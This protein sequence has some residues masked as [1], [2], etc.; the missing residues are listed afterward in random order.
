MSIFSKIKARVTSA[1]TKTTVIAAGFTIALAS[2]AAL[3]TISGAAAA[4]SSTPN[5]T[6]DAAIWCGVSQSGS[7][8]NEIAQVKK[9]YANGDGHNKYYAIQDMYNYFGMS[10]SVIN[11]LSTSNVQS[12]YVTSTGDVYAGSTLVATGAIT[13]GRDNMTGSTT[14]KYGATTFYTRPTHIS[15]ENGELSALVIMKNGTF[16]NAILTSCGNP[17]KATSKKPAVSILK[18]VRAGTSGNYASSVTV[19]S[20]STVSYQI[21]ASS[22]GAISADNVTVK[23]AL[24]TGIAYTSGTLD[25]NGKAMTSTDASKFFGTGLNVGTVKNGSKDV[26]TFTAKAGTVV[27]T[28]AS[29][30]AAIMNN[31][32]TITATGL[33]AQTSGAKVTTTCTPPAPKA[34]LVCNLLT[35]APGAI[36]STTGNQTYSFTAKGTASNTAITGYAFDFGDT[37]TATTTTPTTTHTY[38]PGS[39]TATVTI[40]A[41]SLSATATTCKVTITVK[42]P[43][44]PAKPNYTIQKEVSTTQNG[45]YSSNVSVKSGATVYYKI[46]VSSTGNTPVTNVNVHDVMPTYLTYTN[47]TLQ[48]NGTAVT[49]T[50]TS[51]LFGKGLTVASIKNGSNVVFTYSAVAGNTA[52]DTDASCVAE[53]LTNTGTI[54]TT[55]LPSESG[56]ATT[57]TTCTEVKG[58]L[59]CVAIQPIAGTIDSTTGAQSYTFTGTATAANATIKT[60]TFTVTNTDTNKVV[61]TIPVT[62][63]VPTSPATSAVSLTPGNYSAT[64]TVSGTDLYGNAVSGSTNNNCTTPIKVAT[65][66]CKPGVAMGSSSCYVYSCNDFELTVVNSTRLVTVKTF[67]ATSTDS[68]ATLSNVIINWG[69]NTT[70]LTTN[71]PVGQTHTFTN[72]TS[73]VTAT[74]KFTTPGSTT[75]VSSTVCSQPVSFTTPTTPTPPTMPTVLPNTGAGNVVG[76]FVGTVVAGTIAARYF[77]ARKLARR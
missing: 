31:T 60:Y 40:N 55:G 65:P 2:V 26:F 62:S 3:A 34:S 1:R 23:D 77:M 46:T 33:P 5:C 45:T 12:G 16:Q 32:G 57:K 69:D 17:I 8:S 28:D 25:D 29:C 39:Y 20:G 38:A 66:E 24:P 15:F 7:V 63:S 37:K 74:A 71:V 61:T 48:E 11:G 64:V 70:P 10:T 53:T 44:P 35:A 51:N 19:K 49:S 72:D 59:A 76:L 75:P 42:P 22:T 9:V 43:T 6:A 30:K 67:S 41:G 27:D 58:A 47:G 73:T 14:I 4:P 52:T 68:K 56:S 13:A 50:D 36:D 21:T 54:T 18:Q